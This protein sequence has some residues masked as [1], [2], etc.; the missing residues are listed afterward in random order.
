MK[1]LKTLLIIVVVLGVLLL[2]GWGA[3][4]WFTHQAIPQTSG[5]ITVQGLSQPVEVVRDAY[6][7]AH[8]YAQNPADLYF[9]EGY[10]HAQERFWQME[11]QRRVG[12]GRLSEIFG[13]TTLGT[14]KYLRNFGFYDLAQKTYELL[15]PETKALLDAY[16]AGVNAYISG[17]SPAQLG[18]EFALLGVQGNKWQIEPWKP[19]DSLVWGEMMIYDQADILSP[20]LYN[21]DALAEVGQKMFDDIHLTEYRADRPTI[22]QSRD[23]QGAQRRIPPRLTPLGQK[24]PG[25]DRKRSPTC[26]NSAR[27]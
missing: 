7:V 5:K 27:R 18:L 17:R 4:R 13:D 8:I 20:E 21:I 6:G 26:S 19:A 16:S 15:D 25:W 14:D 24:P 22:I 1:A 2:I 3:F 23:L 9:A 11:F 10:T 12:A